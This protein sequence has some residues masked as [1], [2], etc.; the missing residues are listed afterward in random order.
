[1]G[2]IAG[3]LRHALQ[4]NLSARG[5]GAARDGAAAEQR[6]LLHA[7][8]ALLEQGA[9]EMARRSDRLDAQ[10]QHTRDARRASPEDGA[11]GGEGSVPHA[12]PPDGEGL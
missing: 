6:Q 2:P 12:L 1:M 9:A 11:A 3:A 8:S 5:D 4:D 7:T 10:L